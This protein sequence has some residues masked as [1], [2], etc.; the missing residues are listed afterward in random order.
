MSAAPAGRI[1]PLRWSTV[2]AVVRRPDLWVVG[3][4]TLARM[5]PSGWWRTPPHLP[6]PAPRL[7]AFR[8]VTAYGRPDAD[9][10]AE[11]VISYLAWCRTTA[12]SHRVSTTPG[13]RFATSKRR[14]SPAGRGTAATNALSH[15]QSG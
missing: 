7:W 3:L 12:T 11:D 5:A 9:P 2:R 15:R 14:I 10:E 6:L 13:G 1:G 4:A 8:M